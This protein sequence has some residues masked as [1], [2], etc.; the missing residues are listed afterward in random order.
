MSCSISSAASCSAARSIASRCGG[1]LIEI[2]ATGQ[3]EVSFDLADF[4]HNESRLFGVDT[5]KRDLTASAAVLGALTPVF[6]A[7]DY[8]RRAAS[9]QHTGWPRRKRPIARLRP[10]P[11]A[12]S[13]CGRRNRGGDDDAYLVS[14][15]MGLAVGVAYGLLH[16]RSPA[17]P[18]IAL[19]GLLGMVLGEQM[20]TAARSHDSP[21]AH[22]SAAFVPAHQPKEI[23][24]P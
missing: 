11:P 7:G 2:A 14:L 24:A 18:L 16:V 3:R 15:L 17:P 9:T 21:A 5:L 4:Y 19:V 13:C 12:V 1:R 6:V 22:A 20:A 8:P 10:A 23:E